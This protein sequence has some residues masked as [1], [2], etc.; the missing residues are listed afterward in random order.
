[1]SAARIDPS[2][3]FTR[4]G[5]LRGARRCASFAFAVSPFGFAYGA[6]AAASGFTLDQAL[7][8]SAF[9]FAGASQF[10]ALEIWS[11]PPPYLSLALV[12]LA[13]NAR[14]I[15]QG[16][17]LSPWLFQ[18]PRRAGYASL[19]VLTD[20][21]FAD[22]QAAY[23]RGERDFGVFFGGGVAVWLIWVV[24][25]A[26]GAIAGG[27]LGDLGRFGLDIVVGAVFAMVM[28]TLLR[29]GGSRVAAVAGA[30]SLLLV[31][32]WSPLGWD[33]VAAAIV[34]GVAAAAAQGR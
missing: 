19:L 12:A 25:T 18:A 7:L 34:G 8:V 14:H 22:S 3:S 24:S 21:N 11:S 1:M 6:K 23:Q 29:E 13:I 28:V 26:L 16:A 5:V 17:A 30:A 27:A 20:A 10:A 15:V 31:Q 32:G 33:V 2:A 4:D 9:V